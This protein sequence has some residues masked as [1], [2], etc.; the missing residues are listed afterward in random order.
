[1]SD[2]VTALWIDTIGTLPKGN[3][4]YHE[5][6]TPTAMQPALVTCNAT[7]L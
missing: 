7:L 4:Q 2:V 6:K 1:M 3:S 5:Q